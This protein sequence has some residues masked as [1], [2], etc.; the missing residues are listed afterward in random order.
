[1]ANNV[2]VLKPTAHS[3][4]GI[5]YNPDVGQ[6]RVTGLEP[7]SALLIRPVL[8]QTFN[9]DVSLVIGPDSKAVIQLDAWPVNN[10][11]WSAERLQLSI[12]LMAGWVRG[13]NDASDR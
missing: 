2:N 5:E 6:M 3:T 4:L 13:W 9:A 12:D 10:P 1:M 11:K 8:V 7:G